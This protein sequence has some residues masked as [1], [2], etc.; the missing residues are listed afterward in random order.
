[1]IALV[2]VLVDRLNKLPLFTLLR[3]VR[4][5]GVLRRIFVRYGLDLCIVV[6]LLGNRMLVVVAVRF[7]PVRRDRIVGGCAGRVRGLFI[8]EDRDADRKADL[9]AVQ[10][11]TRRET[12]P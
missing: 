5:A 10:N 1:M 11:A 2:A 4:R 12:S 6:R 3:I 9:I 7:R 8:L